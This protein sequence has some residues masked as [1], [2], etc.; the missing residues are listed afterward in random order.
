M[1]IVVKK[2]EAE[3]ICLKALKESN[4]ATERV[5]GGPF[6]GS[7]GRRESETVLSAKR[8]P[9]ALYW[10]SSWFAAF[11]ANS[12]HGQ[13]PAGNPHVGFGPRPG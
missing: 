2:N 4:R 1:A 9:S 12:R 11:G 7:S 6:G 8:V 5:A 10:P 3:E 13:Y